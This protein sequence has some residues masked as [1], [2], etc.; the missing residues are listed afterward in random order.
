MTMI[1]RARIPIFAIALLA[2]A[3]CARADDEPAAGWI[4]FS[5]AKDIAYDTASLRIRQVGGE[6]KKYF[7]GFSGFTWM[8]GEMEQFGPDKTG[9]VS[10]LRV[11]AGP[12]EIINY[13]V[14]YAPSKT[15]FFN[16]SDFS[17]R[18]DIRGGEVTYL[19]EFLATAVM[20]EGFMGLK[21]VKTPY[22][23]V[24]NQRERDMAI[25]LKANPELAG[26]EVKM[27]RF[28]MTG[29]PPF[30]TKRLVPRADE[31]AAGKKETEKEEK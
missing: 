22:F 17:A 16:R 30:T 24:S 9:H 4:V 13:E 11:P 21:N 23:I 31:D 14:H 26:L 29:R 6:Q 18:F 7:P 1:L 19:G 27:A 12:Y 25:A 8:K 20:L 10:A 3:A 28:K 2:A 15:K 5:L